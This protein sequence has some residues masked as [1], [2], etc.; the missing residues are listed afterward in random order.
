MNENKRVK[1][2]N[3]LCRRLKEVLYF[4]FR[5]ASS[6]SEVSGSQRAARYIYVNGSKLDTIKGILVGGLGD[7]S[8]LT[9]ERDHDQLGDAL[10]QPLIIDGSNQYMGGTKKTWGGC[11]KP[12]TFQLRKKG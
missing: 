3:F 12:I 8:D 2:E 4:Y 6:E 1:R 7:K 9:S 5:K 10:S 11:W